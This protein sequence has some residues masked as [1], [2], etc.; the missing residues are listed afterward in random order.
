MKR[1]ALVATDKTVFRADPESSPAPASGLEDQHPTAI[2]ADPHVAGRA[3]CATGRGGVF[4]TEDGGLSWVASGLDGVALM[5]I[6]CS[7]SH[8]DRIWAGSE[9]S[10][11]W[12]SDDG[13]RTWAPAADL[14]ALPSSGDWAFPPRPDTHHVRWIGCDP[15]AEGRLW[16]AI[17]AGALIRT[18]D[19]GATWKD[20]VAGGPYDTH[21][22][23]V[24]ASRPPL[25]RS[26]AG[27]GFF[28]SRDGGDSWTSPM[29]GLDVTYLRSVAV[30]PGDPETVVVSGATGPRSAYMAGRSDGRIY[31]RE[32]TGEWVRITDGWPSNPSTIAPVLEAG[33]QSGELYAADERGVH[34]SGDGGRS[35]EQVWSFS[36]TPNYLSGLAVLM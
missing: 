9:P 2:A 4:R 13:G 6:A 19:G 36:Q 27:D 12:R 22:L 32:G 23:A 28:E 24:T 26:S 20:R 18:D 31:R 25:V 35:W 29:A 15:S 10:A 3:W 11:V 7:P 30:D 21:Q 5:S 33:R 1:T 16:V 17:E 14:E 34:R 8:P